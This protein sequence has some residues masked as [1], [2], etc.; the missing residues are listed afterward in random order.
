MGWHA[1]VA[2]LE[3]RGNVGSWYYTTFQTGLACGLLVEALLLPI[4]SLRAKTYIVAL[5][6]SRV[7]C[8]PRLCTLLA[9]SKR[10]EGPTDYYAMAPFIYRREYFR[11]SSGAIDTFRFHVWFVKFS[12]VCDIDRVGG[13][14]DA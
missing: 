5:G 12:S 11:S 9:F 13:R 14:A 4:G 6:H 1:H 8:S 2:R 3:R 7:T 10:L